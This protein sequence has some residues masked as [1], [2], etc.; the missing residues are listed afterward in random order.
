MSHNLRYLFTSG[1]LQTLLLHIYTLQ[2]Q[3]NQPV[4]EVSSGFLCVP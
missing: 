1:N 2:V 4:F 3:F